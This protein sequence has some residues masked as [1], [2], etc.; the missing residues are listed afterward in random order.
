MPTSKRAY[1][2]GLAYGAYSSPCGQP[3]GDAINVVLMPTRKA[4]DL[5]DPI[6]KLVKA[7]DAFQLSTFEPLPGVAP[8]RGF[9]TG[10]V[11]DDVAE[12]AWEVDPKT[13]S[14]G[15]NRPSGTAVV[16][17]DRG[18]GDSRDADVWSRGVVGEAAELGEGTLDDERCGCRVRDTE[19]GKVLSLSSLSSAAV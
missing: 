12:L 10:E 2:V 8:G 19:G 14:P 15:R 4:H 17:L 18:R 7:D 11:L 9:S 3:R 6:D 1:N 5:G 16:V 13:P